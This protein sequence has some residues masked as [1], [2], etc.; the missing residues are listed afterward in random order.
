MSIANPLSPLQNKPQGL[1]NNVSSALP[2]RA[3]ST[4]AGTTKGVGDTV[5]GVSGG[6]GEGVGKLGQGDVVGGVGSTVGGV[7]KGVSG[8]AS[9]MFF[10]LFLFLFLSLS[11][12]LFPPLSVSIAPSP[13]PLHIFLF[14][15]PLSFLC[16][17]VVRVVFSL[18]PRA[19]GFFIH[20][21]V[22]GFSQSIQVSG[23]ASADRTNSSKRSEEVEFHEESLNP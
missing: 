20:A 3:G 22:R 19:K 10:F 23:A 17:S 12:F 1:G 5:S 18:P 7:G 6:V 9:G 21:N 8:L 16:M 4:V 13:S 14:L 2:G 15:S 11:P